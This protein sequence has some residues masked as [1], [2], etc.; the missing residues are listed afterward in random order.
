M[1]NDMIQASA[2]APHY[3]MDVLDWLK[4][5]LA[6]LNDLLFPYDM[7]ANDL[8]WAKDRLYAAISFVFNLVAHSFAAL[9][10]FAFYIVWY[11]PIAMTIVVQTHAK[12]TP[13]KPN[14]SQNTN[15]KAR[16]KNNIINEKI[17]ILTACDCIPRALTIPCK[18]V[19]NSS[20]QR[21]K[22]ERGRTS[23]QAF[24]TFWLVVKNEIRVSKLR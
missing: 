15:V 17:A 13:K 7:L 24:N 9:C 8:L 16:G 1:S 4:E 21:D 20:K 11:K 10:Q 12:Y 18:N 23:A 3:L 2:G 22:I 19:C 14:L 6:L 5:K